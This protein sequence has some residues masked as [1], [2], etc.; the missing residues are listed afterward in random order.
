LYKIA[1]S[2]DLDY[3]FNNGKRIFYV[4]GVGVLPEYRRSGIAEQLS[5]ALINELRRQGFDYRIGRTDKTADAMRNLYLKQGFQELPVTDAD[6]PGRTYWL[7][8]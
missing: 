3:L 7:L 4:S 5:A 6:Y 1:G 8:Q 2:T